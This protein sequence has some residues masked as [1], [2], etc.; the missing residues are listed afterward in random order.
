[1]NSFAPLDRTKVVSVCHATLTYLEKTE[2]RLAP[3]TEQRAERVK[4]LLCLAEVST[5]KTISVSAGDFCGNGRDAGCAWPLRAPYLGG[6]A[7]RSNR[8]DRGAFRRIL[9][10]IR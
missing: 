2:V 9:L 6:R 3:G 4:R 5:A 1:M 10:K 8:R 7:T